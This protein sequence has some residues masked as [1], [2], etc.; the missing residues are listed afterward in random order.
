MAM[1]GMQKPHW[2]APQLA[3]AR[4]TSDGSPST[5]RPSTVRTSL[6]AA[7]AAGTRQEATS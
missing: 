5:A 7:V 1:P 3:R 6:P 2:T 4:W